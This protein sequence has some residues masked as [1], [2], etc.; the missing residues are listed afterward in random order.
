MVDFAAKVVVESYTFI[1][2]GKDALPDNNRASQLAEQHAF[3]SKKIRDVQISRQPLD[4]EEAAVQKAAETCA[5]STSALIEL[6]GT[7]KVESRPGGMPQWIRKTSA[8]VKTK[9]RRGDIEARQQDVER[10][11][12]MLSNAL[13]LLIRQRQDSQFKDIIEM[14]DRRGITNVSKLLE[15]RAEILGAL[16]DRQRQL[17]AMEATLLARHAE[18]DRM[19]ANIMTAVADSQA[20]ANRH[21][22]ETEKTLAKLDADNTEILTFLQT[23]DGQRTLDTIL[24]SLK[25]GGI[26]ARRTLIPTAAKVTFRWVF[27]AAR[28]PLPGWLAGEGSNIF[29]MSG[30]AGSGKSTLMKYLRSHPETTK[31]LHTWAGTR[32]LLIGDHFF[33][34]A[35]FQEQK[36]QETLLLSMLHDI[37][38]AV[39][40]LAFTLC[41]DRC[42]ANAADQPWSRNELL[43][44][45][46]R[47]NLV[48]DTSFVF[49]VDGLDEY[50][51]DQY[52]LLEEMLT[53]AKSSNVRICMSSRPW[54]VFQ[55]T[56]GNLP[57][58]ALHEL[59]FED[60]RAYIETRLMDAELST[61]TPG[62]F[63]ANTPLASRLID[64]FA[65]NAEGVF[66][67]VYLV[68]NSLS[69]RIVGGRDI[70]DLQRTLEDVP[71]QLEEFFKKLCFDRISSTWR[72]RS[73]T[74]CSLLLA[75]L[76]A[77]D[78]STGSRGQ[79]AAASFINYWLLS[80]SEQMDQAINILHHD[81]EHYDHNRLHQMAL[82]T[83]QYLGQSCRD[84][85]G[86][87]HD[88]DEANPLFAYSVDFLHRT[89]YDFLRLPTMYQE[90]IA[91]T[92][93][94]FRDP[95]FASRLMLARLKVVPSELHNLQQYYGTMISEWSF[96]N[97]ENQRPDAEMKAEYAIVAKHYTDLFSQPDTVDMDAT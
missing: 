84:L 94:D 21:A 60:V 70:Q 33:W 58:F 29:W 69:E 81:I 87:H 54:I 16:E 88:P 42:Q 36:N 75:V 45:L 41:P 6:L 52:V 35:G 55:S 50:S 57:R 37:I 67:W 90:L 3:L 95:L 23:E 30:K 39:P 86:V 72:D 92:P 17:R 28:S 11:K 91:R 38:S 77:N 4:E 63:Q 74:A 46:C 1:R 61:G 51:G 49:F 27:D 59:T 71:A 12:T 20:N 85:I 34:V 78:P 80:Q 68:A 73:D 66:L 53:V 62:G 15:C 89:V 26:K 43:E 97:H 65:M 56:L 14:I 31:L 79:A 9:F 32:K 44:A 19:D 2:S 76:L 22:R 18:H 8:V 47:M 7:L 82:S 24:K 40:T 93:Q 5:G 13:L 64:D 96:W 83:K 25:Y 48:A 10:G